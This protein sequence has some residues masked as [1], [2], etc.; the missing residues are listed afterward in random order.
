MVL[1]RWFWA[2]AAVL[3]ALAAA[4]CFVPLFNL[5]GYEFAFAL[6][7]AAAV[8][9]LVVGLAVGRARP[10]GARA[11]LL[12]LLLASSQLLVPLALISLNALRVKNCN[13]G[14]GLRFFFLLPLPTT[15]YGASLGVLV[16][17]LGRSRGRL[18][19]GAVAALLPVGALAWTL[20]NLYWQPPIV[21]YDH[22]LGH[23]AGSLYDEVIQLDARLLVFRLGTLL[24]VAAIAL[25]LEAYAASKQGHA[26]R[27]FAAGLLALGAVIAFESGLGPRVGFR[28]D[29]RDILAVLSEV[30]E[31]PGLVIHL[32][33]GLDAERRHAIADDHEFRLTEVKARLGIEQVRTIHSFVYANEEEKGRL[34]GA[35]GTMVSKPWLFEIHVHDAIAPHPLVGH[36]LTHAVAAELAPGPLHVSSRF[37]LLVNLGLVEGVAEALTV[38]QGELDGDV[39]SHALRQLK[40][41]PDLRLILGSAGFWTEAPRRAYTVAGSF[42][43]FLLRTFGPEPLRRVYAHG[44]FESAYG[45]PLSEL[46]KRWEAYVD[47]SPLAPRELAMAAEQFRM[48]AIFARPCAHEIAALR[49]AAAHAPA[50][51]AV[52]LY[53]EINAHLGNSPTSR[54]ELAL[55]MR[56]Q[57]AEGGFLELSQQL[58]GGEELTA[59]ERARLLEAKGELAWERGDVLEARRAFTEV[60]GLGLSPASERLQWVRLWALGKDQA[61]AATLR[62]LLTEK[63]APLAAV[64]EL[65][66]RARREPG[67]KTIPYLVARQLHRVAA[68][69]QALRYLEAAGPHPY[70]AIEAER[71]RL[72]ADCWSRLHHPAEASAAYARY[73]EAAPTSGERA[74]AEDEIER[75]RWLARP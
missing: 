1:G 44:D 14:V 5:L 21:A 34:M 12:A 19:R 37:G 56:R 18:T 73:A 66:E 64:L 10:D 28:V 72:I 52:R 45:L 49:E 54:C 75:L 67:D 23:F 68:Y 3:A 36:E 47:A 46:V 58:L 20:W 65:A 17:Q 6:G 63:L 31:R 38:P 27:F 60:L 71:L 16:A 70:P 50:A 32:P 30:E 41:A 57:G 53:G 26:R 40:L 4:L 74:R 69:E 62:G 22:L 24:R 2:T 15:L 33:K 25:M 29:R 13:Y 39:W 48:P 42:V 51:E 61:L 7:I 43:R 59:A 35:H 8:T 9:S 55:A 11:L